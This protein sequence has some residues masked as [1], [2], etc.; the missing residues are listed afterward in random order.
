MAIHGAGLLAARESYAISHAGASIPHDG[1]FAE[2]LHVSGLALWIL[3]AIGFVLAAS[4]PGRWRVLLVGSAVASAIA[5]VFELQWLVEVSIDFDLY[6]A[7]R[8]V[9]L[10]GLASFAGAAMARGGSKRLTWSLLPMSVALAAVTAIRPFGVE[11]IGIP[12][13]AMACYLAFDLLGAFPVL[14]AR[15]P[16]ASARGA[17]SRVAGIVSLAFV[18][19]G[20]LAMGLALQ[21]S[22]ALDDETSG[23]FV[24]GMACLLPGVLGLWRLRGR[25]VWVPIVVAMV[26]AGGSI[27]SFQMFWIRPIDRAALETHRAG[28][29]RVDLPLGIQVDEADGDSLLITPDHSQ[30][31]SVEWLWNIDEAP[32]EDDPI[33]SWTV[34]SA[35]VDVDARIYE[36]EDHSLMAMVAW[37]C[38]ARWSYVYIQ[39]RSHD[40]DGP[41]H[42]LTQRVAMS[43]ACDPPR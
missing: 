11:V 12:V 3:A 19:A 2:L 37:S 7:G 39:P 26:F 16:P 33:Q 10:L 5:A 17:A 27:N 18:V 24:F 23:A 42:A 4:A 43:A 28:G 9:S 30:L 1:T 21:R 36:L 35:G 22:R 13:F 6:R 14:D 34:R 29:F 32:V 15:I 8:A 31:R 41:L 20:G 38:G 25:H 40:D